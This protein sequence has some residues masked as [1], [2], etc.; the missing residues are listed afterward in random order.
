MS[1]ARATEIPMTDCDLTIGCGRD[2]TWLHFTSS[3]GRSAS[4]NI[5]ALAERNGSIIGWALRD[6]CNARQEQADQIRR[7][8]GQF[9]VGA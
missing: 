4:L 6:W 3:T 7:D 5:E 9:G 1:D 2:G 8:N